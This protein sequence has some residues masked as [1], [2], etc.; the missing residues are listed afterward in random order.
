MANGQVS[1]ITVMA[2]N[3]YRC[4]EEYP[5]REVEE[6]L[7]LLNITRLSLYRCLIGFKEEAVICSGGIFR[8]VENGNNLTVADIEEYLQNE[9]SYSSKPS[10]VERILYLYNLLH[11][12][13]PYGGVTF[14]DIMQQ[15]IT[16]LEHSTDSLPKE[17]SISRNIYRDIE[18]LE[19][20][21]IIIDRPSTGNKKY[22][23]RD[24]YLPKLSFEQA[25]SLYV[26]MLLFEDTILDQVSTSAKAEFEKAFFK[27]SPHQ[28]K[29]I[30][31]RIHVVGD[32]LVN[33][34]EFSDRFTKLITAVIN[35]Y[36]ISINYVKLN[37][38]TLERL[39]NPVGLIYKRGVWYLVAKNT[40]N[41]EY[42]T[43][44]IDQI[45]AVNLMNIQFEYPDNFSLTEHIGSSWGVFTND[46]VQ[47][48]KLKFSPKV[49]T[50][51]K[52]LRYH[53]TQEIIEERADGSI[54]IGL[55]ICGLIE[56]K[57]WLLQW[58]REVEVLEPLHLRQELINAANEILSVYNQ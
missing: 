15:Y 22:C 53:R 32:T 8:V 1:N 9:T 13:I 46:E 56:L 42:R 7:I 3:I 31:E 25:S 51:V 27:N 18:E 35:S 28:S 14:D 45:L 54:I 6:L 38:E 21:G 47:N 37:G 20:I 43:F 52:N 19:K 11:A 58:G 12:N 2:T 36:Q 16:L 41:E 26:S 30:A 23:L 39:L 5:D 57:S 44:R 48:V 33:P 24:K 55:E 40:T 17:K 50:R 29:K 4:I 34:T 49:R 10:K